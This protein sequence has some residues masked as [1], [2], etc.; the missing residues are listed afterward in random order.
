MSATD[1]DAYDA[2]ISCLAATRLFGSLRLDDVERSNEASIA[3]PLAI[4][5]PGSWTES[6]TDDPTRLIRRITYRVTLRVRGDD[7]RTRFLETDRLAHE[8]IA[9]L[10]GANFGEGC[11][12]SLST[13]QRGESRLSAGNGEAIC[14]LVGTFSFL[15]PASFPSS[16][17]TT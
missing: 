16:I 4:I 12:P 5:S 1:C 2:M 7:L 14:E 9:R 15:V 6:R 11:V 10:N 13:I 17:T 8:V 3:S